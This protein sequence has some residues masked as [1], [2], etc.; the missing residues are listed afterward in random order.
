MLYAG[1]MV[2]PQTQPATT[3]GGGGSRENSAV[4]FSKVGITFYTQ[5]NHYA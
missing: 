3:E 5:V 1:Q 4:D 2:S